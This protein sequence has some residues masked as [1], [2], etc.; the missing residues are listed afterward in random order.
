[1]P[2][3]LEWRDF[4]MLKGREE[5]ML[6]G[7]EQHGGLDNRVGSWLFSMLSAPGNLAAQQGA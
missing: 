7:S 4:S 6:G 5:A 3:R 2:T 1:M